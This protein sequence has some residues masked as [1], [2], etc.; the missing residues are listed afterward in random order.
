MPTKE[1]I[2][3]GDITRLKNLLR[4]YK[5]HIITTIHTRMPHKKIPDI[6]NDVDLAISIIKSGL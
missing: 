5:A 4:D 1:I 3:K 6:I 2:M